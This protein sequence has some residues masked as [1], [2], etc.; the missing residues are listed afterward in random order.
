MQVRL[1]SMVMMFAILYG[2]LAAPETAHAGNSMTMHGI[3]AVDMHDHIDPDDRNDQQQ[4][5]GS[6]C[7]VVVHHHCSLA[8]AVDPDAASLTE[9]AGKA[10]VTPRVVTPMRSLA[11][12]PPTEP[13]SA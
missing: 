2:S 5:G 6:P 1:L 3:E 10:V 13:P 12:A 11:L 8:L 7:H 4:K 9:W